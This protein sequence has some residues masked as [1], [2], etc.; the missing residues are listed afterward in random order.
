ML[1]FGDGLYLRY[2]GFS[3]EDEE[4]ILFMDERLELSRVLI[5]GCLFCEDEAGK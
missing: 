4:Y 1:K 2:R 5:E 3:S